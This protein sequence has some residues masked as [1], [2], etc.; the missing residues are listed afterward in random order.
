MTC[1][2]FRLMLPYVGG[3]KSAA[4]PPAEFMRRNCFSC[5]ELVGAGAVD[6]LPWVRQRP[7]PGPPLRDTIPAG[8]RGPPRWARRPPARRRFAPPFSEACRCSRMSALRSSTRRVVCRV[9]T[10]ASSPSRWRRL[11]RT[12][13]RSTRRRRKRRMDAIGKYLESWRDRVVQNIPIAGQADTMSYLLLGLA[14]IAISRMRRPMRR[15]SS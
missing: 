10:T 5:A 15:R 9:T 4:V 8:R 3:A 11:A 14:P 13:T 1:D 6:R 12:V 7:R 2:M